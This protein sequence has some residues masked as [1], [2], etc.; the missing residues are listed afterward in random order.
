[1]TWDILKNFCKQ[2]NLWAGMTFKTTR[3]GRV[4]YIPDPKNPGE[5]VSIMPNEFMQL[6]AKK[7]GFEFVAADHKTGTYTLRL[8]AD[9]AQ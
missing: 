8:L 5:F 1:M 9:P 2:R 4:G 7:H 3:L 6:A